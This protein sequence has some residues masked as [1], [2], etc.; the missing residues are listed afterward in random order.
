VLAACIMVKLNA[1]LAVGGGRLVCTSIQVDETPT[2]TVIFEGDVEVVLPKTALERPWWRRADMSIN[3][4]EA[5][6]PRRSILQGG[7]AQ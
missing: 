2:N 6:A 4:L 7:A 1:F 5:V 3:D